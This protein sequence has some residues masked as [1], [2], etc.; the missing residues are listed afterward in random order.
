MARLR[1]EFRVSMEKLIWLQCRKRRAKTKVQVQ[2]LLIHQPLL[3][4]LEQM[5]AWLRRPWR[6]T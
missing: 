3:L 4:S 1:S 5:V 2:Q 6:W